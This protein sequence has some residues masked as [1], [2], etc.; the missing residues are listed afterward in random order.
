MTDEEI[1]CEWQ[2]GRVKDVVFQDMETTCSGE[3][4][5]WEHVRKRD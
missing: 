5:M 2:G 3:S 1:A 4:S